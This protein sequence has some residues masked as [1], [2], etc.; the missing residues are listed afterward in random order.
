[1]GA[2]RY[3]EERQRAPDRYGEARYLLSRILRMRDLNR[4]KQ[5]VRDLIEK[6]EREDQ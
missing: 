6:W 1:M 2:D 5:A 3:I 4:V